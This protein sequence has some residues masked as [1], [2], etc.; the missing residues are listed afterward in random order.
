MPASGNRY[1]KSVPI[2]DPR[3]TEP[4]SVGCDIWERF[5]Q[6]I[7]PPPLGGGVGIVD[8]VTA[9][10]VTQLSEAAVAVN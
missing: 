5:C 4:P 7:E 2:I 3:V 6:F 9:R 10:F 8:E 1:L